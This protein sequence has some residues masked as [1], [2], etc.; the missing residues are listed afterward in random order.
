MFF[1]G[2]NLA[3]LLVTVLIL[4]GCGV[5]G[6][7]ASCADQSQEFFTQID[8]LARRWDDANQLAG[9]TPR[10]QLA[11][12]IANLQAVR[13]EVQDLKPPECSKPAQDALV[14]TMDATIQGYID[15]LAQKPD[16]TVSES[17]DLAKIRML[18]YTAALAIAKGL[19]ANSGAMGQ[20]VITPGKNGP[21][22]SVWSKIGPPATGVVGTVSENDRVDVYDTTDA[23]ALIAVPDGTHGWVPREY[24]TYPSK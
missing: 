22:V 15:F 2:F 16:S 1:R 17:F 19:P 4:T 20:G 8:P 14:G 18:D 11:G 23:G 3:V 12:Q 6:L 9:Q 7:S 10:M 5:P 13:R 24:I 21:K